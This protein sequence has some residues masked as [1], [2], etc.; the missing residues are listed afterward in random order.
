V[1]SLDVKKE[2]KMDSL[3]HIAIAVPD[4]KR[5]LEWYRRQFDVKT[6][7][8]DDTWALLRFHNIDLA[9]VLPGHHP[10]H[11]AIERPDAESFGPLKMHRDGSSSTYLNDT[12]GN[13]IEVIKDRK[14]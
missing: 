4:I 12:F 8:E 3:D 14:V 11:I 13:V 10:P 5:A 1:T 9:L 7:Y 6:V 2:L